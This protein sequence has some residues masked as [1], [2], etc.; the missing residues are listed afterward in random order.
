ME[1]ATSESE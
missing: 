1:Q